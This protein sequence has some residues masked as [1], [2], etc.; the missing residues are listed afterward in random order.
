MQSKSKSEA[1]K[2]I[3]KYVALE[4]IVGWCQNYKK[5]DIGG[6]VESFKRYGFK[7]PLK[8]E[9][10]LNDGKGGIVEGNGRLEAL[11]ALKRNGNEPPRGILETK[12]GDWAVPVLFG[13]DAE[14]E[15]QA[16][17]YAI[18]H[19]N[20]TMSGGDFNLSDIARMW[21][22]EFNTVLQ[23]LALN[24]SAP[25]SINLDDI[26]AMMQIEKNDIE[27]FFNQPKPAEK[28]PKTITCPN[29][30]EVIKL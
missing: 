14:N 1:E 12:D 29:C 21:G 7:D 19:N 27:Q 17:A 2:I 10:L 9:P 20:L 25:I 18:D 15:K 6:I 8:F 13:I 3:L 23:N 5:H 26:N 22:S 24:D 30:G 11:F 28:I 4:S 16:M